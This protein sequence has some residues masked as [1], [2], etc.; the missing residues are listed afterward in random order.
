MPRWNRLALP[1]RTLAAGILCGVL[2]TAARIEATEPLRDT[3]TWRGATTSVTVRPLDSGLRRYSFHNRD[4]AAKLQE[5]LVSESPDG[6]RLRTGSTLFDGLYA[7]ALTEAKQDSVDEIRDGQFND[8]KPIPCR[9]FETGLKWPYVWTRDISYSVDLALAVLDPQRSQASLLFKTSTLRPELIAA[10]LKDVRVVAQD[11]GSGGSWPVSTDR[12]VWI[13]AAMDV[14]D[15]L[16][17]AGSALRADVLQ[18]A[19][20][21]LAQDRRYAYDARAGLYRGETS[22]LD[23][24]EQTYPEWTRADTRF[25]AEGFALSTNVL[26]YV[27]LRDTARLMRPAD[28][29]GAARFE[30]EADALKSAINARFW[31]PAS[32]LYAS[33]LS[34]DLA[35]AYA[36]DLLGIALAIQHGVADPERAREMLAAYPVTPAGPPVIWPEQPD[37][38]IYHN[39]AIWQFVTAYALRAAV[40]VG[41]VAH[42]TAYAESIVRGAALSLSNYENQEF[43]TQ[44][45]AFADGPL[46]GPVIN[47]PRQLWSVA[48]YAGM[49]IHDLFGIRVGDGGAVSVAPALPGALAH[50]IAR[51]HAPLSLN[52]LAVAGRTLDVTLDLPAKWSDNDV[53]EVAATDIDG[54][55]V[56]LDAAVPPGTHRVV[57]HLRATDAARVPVRVVNATDPRHL[58]EEEQRALFAPVPPKLIT[59][60]DNPWRITIQAG[61]LAPNNR[62]QLYVDGVERGDISEGGIIQMELDGDHVPCFAATQSWPDRGHRSLP[63]REEC[64]T[65]ISVTNSDPESCFSATGPVHEVR[66]PV[67]AVGGGAASSRVGCLHPQERT[68]GA[69]EGLHPAGDSAPAS[70]SDGKTSF[71]D[72]GTATDR[73]GFSDRPTTDGPQRLTLAYSNGYGPVNTGVTAAVKEVTATCP[74]MVEPQ[75]GTIVMPHLANSSVIDLSTSFQYQAKRGEECRIVVA[76]GFNMSYLSHFALYTAAR[77]GKSGAWNR[78]T[79]HR[80]IVTP[81]ATAGAATVEAAPP[82]PR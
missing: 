73:L 82:P 54:L 69:S 51:G 45:T 72:W 18:I 5:R 68:Y 64:I 56:A 34:R 41:D 15:A 61:L 39:R 79:I 42:A 22:F 35:S 1:V 48:G 71:I 27:A 12:V 53:L 49:V 4:A 10:G 74:S 17:P 52:N 24:R 28:S 23:W 40:K 78:A 6:S 9:C 31:V 67:P 43:L 21:T 46:S 57:A 37:V 3:L 63:S 29:G 14:V 13:H 26:H 32:H 33:Y 25:I 75:W 11:T 38:A 60:S 36:Y 30:A 44:S 76:D 62:W 66:I 16:G 59:S 58:T 70:A 80:A 19:T 55:A 7:L 65:S 81:I 8:G 77:G 20:D 47:S 2:C 50:R